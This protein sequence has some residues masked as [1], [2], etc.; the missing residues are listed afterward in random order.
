MFDLA[1]FIT[2]FFKINPP[3]YK[4]DWENVYKAMAVHTKKEMPCDLISTQ[5]PNETAEILAYRIANHRAITYGSMN[6]ALDE[7]YRI[8]SG[9]SYK[10][11]APENVVQLMG[12]KKF[13][14]LTFNLFLQQFVLRKMIEDPNALLVWL[15]SG[16]GIHKNT[17]RAIPMPY[18]VESCNIHYVGDEVLSFLSHEKSEVVISVD[19]KRNST[20]SYEGIVFYVLTKDAFYKLKQVGAKSDNKF[21]LELVY[22]HEIGEIPYCVLGGDMSD[23][24]YYN[25]Y[26]APYLACGDEAICRFSDWQATMVMSS[27]PFIEEFQI[28]CEVLEGD[29]AGKH[30]N[31][32]PPGEEKF[33][34]KKYTLKPHTKSPLGTIIR[35]S[36]LDKNNPFADAGL[37][38]SIP[39]IRFIQANVDTAKY[40]GESWQLLIEMA[41]DALHLNLGRGLLSGDAKAEDKTA[42]TTMISKIGN[43]FFDNIMLSSAI[44]VD[45]YYNH[46]KANHE[47]ISIDKPNTYDIKTEGDIV[48][49]ITVLK[50]KMAPAFFLQE[51]T[52]DLA[53]KRF[54]G[55]RLSQK[56]FNIIS[57]ADPLYIYSIPDKQS[58]AISGIITKEAYIKSIYI[59]SLL[60][61]ISN[62]IGIDAFLDATNEAIVAKLDTELIQYYPQA[63]TLITDPNGVPVE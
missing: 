13:N 53:A 5:R 2:D 17:E 39:S 3:R 26:F 49:E 25:S 54:S 6:R 50:E 55:N 29:D 63:K 47:E 56:I 57:I 32:I 10:I 19:S 61:K 24:G 46:R 41:E 48:N 45:A 8:V 33:Q 9:I 36:N 20:T 58:M 52:L 35:K 34:G 18:V 30:S 42:Q 21:Q 62:D 12:Q 43:N 59:F 1:K 7:L 60:L 31:P 23:Y 22:E 14:N 51:S 44:Y 27:F 4:K 15:P 38:P 40:A 28:E 16:E 11:N 37:D